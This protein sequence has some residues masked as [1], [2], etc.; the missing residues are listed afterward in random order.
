MRLRS[1]QTL[2]IFIFSLGFIHTASAQTSPCDL[3]NVSHNPNAP[4][5][6]SPDSSMYLVNAQDTDGVYQIYVAPAGDTNLTC[7]SLN[8]PWS[9]LRPWSARNKMQVQWAPTGNFIICAVEKEFYNELLYV[10][11]NILL[12]WLQSGLWMDIMAVTPD[13]NSWYSLATTEAGFTGPAF[14][15]DG[16]KCAWAE[17]RDSSNIFVD[18]FGVWKLQFS[19]YVENNGIPSFATTNDI[20]PAGARWVEPGNFNPVDG[21]L[22]LITADIG[23]TNAEG[24][25]QFIINVSNG[26]IAN[27]NN[28]PMVWDEHGVFSPDG[29]KILFM[30]S[31][32]YQADT[33]SYHTLTIK[34]EFMLM[35]PDGS[36]L[37]QLTHFCD[38]GYVESH[39]G[40]AATGYWGRG[41]STIY[42]Q[43]LVFPYYENWKIKFAGDCGYTV[44][45]VEEAEE[46]NFSFF[47]NPVQNE[48]TIETGI[49]LQDAQIVITNSLGQTVKVI[50]AVSGNKIKISTEELEDGIY[51]LHIQSE[52]Q[53]SSNIFI[54]CK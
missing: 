6:Y 40:I 36:G 49:E 50:S 42:A 25:D 23:I 41:D 29:S 4:I 11:Y 3:V 38:T 19:T 53:H 37:Q 10:P 24:Q 2:L 13:G 30:S 1:F 12:G 32:P 47:P 54:K 31:Y 39:P 8:Y 34:T 16:T 7:I 28:T 17:A 51:F 20:T 46:N 9:F 33:N 45:S 35:N 15:P 5:I 22:L 27:L 18:V 48:L 14:T 44:T 52:Q 43:S 21:N 26:Q